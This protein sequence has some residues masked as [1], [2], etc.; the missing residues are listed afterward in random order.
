MKERTMAAPADLLGRL[1]RQAAVLAIMVL[2]GGG[3]GVL[4][5]RLTTP[6]YVADAHVVVLPAPPSDDTTAVKFAQAYGRI[7]TEP[8]VLA[9]ASSTV[10]G[11]SP[12]DLRRQLRVSTSPAAPL[13]QL[14]G[15]APTAQRAAEVANEVATA[16][17]SFGN[18]RS[19]QTRVRLAMFAEASPPAQP[20]SP[21]QP[22]DIAV[23]AA[24]GLLVGALAVTAGVGA[25]RSAR[26]GEDY[27]AAAVAR[28][29]RTAA[30][31]G[32]GPTAWAP[33]TGPDRGAAEASQPAARPAGTP[34]DRPTP[35][36]PATGQPA[37]H[38]LL[39]PRAAAAGNV[40]SDGARYP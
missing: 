7:A 32:A 9:A 31:A 12:D 23:G 22:L 26:R 14:T 1:L 36:A 38:E 30:G 24:A 25:S 20:S 28:A 29:D 34:D 35:Q 16:L 37:M 21:N 18:A 3:A 39:Q 2:L 33:A 5:A 27:P 11:G 10:R 8:A 19:S 6:T 13:V 40:R 4:Y 15:S 17:V